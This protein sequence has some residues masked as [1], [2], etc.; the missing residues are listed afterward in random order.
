MV[1]TKADA[2]PAET[3]EPKRRV[4]RPRSAEIDRAV[5]E[6]ALDLLVERGYAGLSIEGVAARAEVGKAAIYRRWST[7]A[8]LVVDALGDR[9]CAQF[10]LV[11][12][13][14]LRADLV[15]MLTNVQ[16]AMAGDEG[17]VMAAFVAEKARYPELRAEFE[18]VFISQRRAHLQRLVRAAVDRGELP[19]DTDVELLAEAGPSMLSHHYLFHSRD[20]DPGLPQRIVDLLLPAST[21]RRSRQAAK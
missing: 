13:G 2:E 10:P 21:P 6:A 20:L 19:A 3:C 4:G 11:D 1:V 17:P 18:R 12:T 14:D 8:E 7:K 9:G 16:A 5:L 15:A